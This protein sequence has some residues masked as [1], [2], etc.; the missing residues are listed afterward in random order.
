M[1]RRGSRQEKAVAESFLN[2]PGR[3]RLRRTVCRTRAKARQHVFDS[4]AMVYNPTRKY[5]RNA[6][7]SPVAFE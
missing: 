6:M 1:I 7:L 5:A 4:I 2:L 3:E